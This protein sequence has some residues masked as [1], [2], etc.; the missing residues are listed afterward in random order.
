MP[1]HEGSSFRSRLVREARFSHPFH[2]HPEIEITLIRR[3]GGLRLVGD[4]VEPFA[5]GDLCL[6]GARLPHRYHQ[7]TGSDGESEAEVIQFRRDCGGGFL[8]EAPEMSSFARLLD[9]A[10]LG[11]RFPPETSEKAAP[12]FP[13]IRVAT[14]IKRWRALL[15]LLDQLAS[16]PPPIQLASPG[17]AADRLPH[18]QD[19]IG[20]ACD[21][22]LEHFDSDLDHAEVARLVHLSPSAF[23]RLFRRTTGKTYTAFLQEVRLGHACRLLRETNL[24]ITEVALASGFQNLSNF[25]RR[26]RQTYHRTPREYR[27]L[28]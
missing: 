7:G 11:L 13:R 19:R 12:L 17:Y 28:G 22:L 23:S 2:Y 25:N 18:D 6:I 24:L 4:H 8:D 20:R 26:F 21:H 16:G 10:S 5:P 27:Q 3:G 1:V 15:A 14:G 9:A